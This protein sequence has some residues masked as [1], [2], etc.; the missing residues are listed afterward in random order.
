LDFAASLEGPV[1]SGETY[2]NAP[3]ELGRN[4]EEMGAVLPSHWLDAHQ[5]Q[6]SL[7]HQSGRL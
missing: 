1:T 2:Q 3:H 7:I 4:T 6:E 5:S